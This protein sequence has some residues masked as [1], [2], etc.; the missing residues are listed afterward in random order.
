MLEPMQRHTYV[1]ALRAPEGYSLEAAVGTTFSL[2]LS[3]LLQ[4]PLAMTRLDDVTSAKDPAAIMEALRRTAERFVVFCHR[5]KIIVPNTN[6]PIISQLESVVQEVM[7]YRRYVAFHPKIWVIRFSNNNRLNPDVY[8]FCCLSRN[9]TSDAS[10]DTAFI[11]EGVC[12]KRRI[13]RNKPLID[14]LRYLLKQVGAENKERVGALFESVLPSLPY[15]NFHLPPWVQEF[16]FV[17]M[18][19]TQK[20]QLQLPEVF[21]QECRNRLLI[22]SPFLSKGFLN[23]I[24]SAGSGHILISRQ[25]EMDMIPTD[26][27][28]KFSHKYVWEDHDTPEPVEDSNSNYGPAHDVDGLHA[29]L[30]IVDRGWNSSLLSG[31]P[32]ATGRAFERNIEFAV[33]IQG[34]RSQIGVDHVLGEPGK[35]TLR[36]LLR[37]YTPMANPA[38][39]DEEAGIRK[40]LELH[41]EEIARTEWHGRV[42]GY[43]VGYDLEVS[44]SK[45]PKL[46]DSV[47]MK[48]RPVTLGVAQAQPLGHDR[49]AVFKGISLAAITQFWAFALSKKL[50]S[51]KK[52]VVSF[53]LKV[54]VAGIPEGRDNAILR[55]VISDRRAFL[56]Y[57]LMLLAPDWLP[58]LAKKNPSGQINPSAGNESCAAEMSL[59]WFEDLIRTASRDPQKLQAADKLIEDLASSEGESPVLPAGFLPLWRIVIKEVREDW[60]H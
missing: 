24:A 18:F 51:G 42:V 32:N 57:L 25:E 21:T 16:A 52:V 26:V 60:Q 36:S 55:T 20:A 56:R 11:T 3:G 41:A 29:K 35:G 12:G 34:K 58:L 48:V 1:D 46:P 33:R 23:Q 40:R 6:A 43:A 27:L 49:K 7:P 31:S 30:I 28:N 14:F 15:V 4:L 50:R 44:T 5:G 8:R 38:Q 10:W 2:D 59:P 39:P 37:E 17:P 19:G 53:T 47:E 9:L 22:A 45:P 13:E 54:P